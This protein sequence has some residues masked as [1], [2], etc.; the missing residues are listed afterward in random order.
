MEA[1]SAQWR[2]LHEDNAID[3]MA[4]AISFAE[5]L[6]DLL[7]KKVLELTEPLAF[8]A[9]LRSRH[10]TKGV[11]IAVS[12]G[13]QGFQLAASSIGGRIYNS[14]EQNVAPGEM[15]PTKVIEQLQVEQAAIYYRS[16]KY[17]PWTHQLSRLVPL[18][19]PT[20]ATLNGVVAVSSLR[21]EYLDRF[22]FD[23]PSTEANP[24]KLVKRPN[25][26]VAEHI[27]S[28][29]DLWHCHTG[30]YFA[31]TASHKQLRQ[32]SLDALDQAKG[33]TPEE[34]IVR[35]INMR[36]ARE[37]RFLDPLD[38]ENV[39]DSTI[40]GKKLDEMHLGLKQDLEALILDEFVARI[41][42]W[43]LRQ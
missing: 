2:P 36:L 14:V 30:S 26:Y 1:T 31:G 42:L 17:I 19:G 16:W 40:L 6:P 28:A 37:E 24:A 11:P 32:I 5:P 18:F 22:I 12:A 10:L 27:F 9:G 4:V 38:P 3:V 8:A 13:T 33:L 20:L 43:E 23:G 34:G 21:L 25:V 39:L 29:S 15:P 41:R 7:F 35:V